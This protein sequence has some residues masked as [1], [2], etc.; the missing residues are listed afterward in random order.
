[1]CVCARACVA[2]ALFSLFLCFL[3]C[4]L[5]VVVWEFS[6]LKR[7]V[8]RSVGRSAV[9]AVVGP[10]GEKEEEEAEKEEHEKDK[11]NA[12]DEAAA[13]VASPVHVQANRHHQHHTYFHHDFTADFVGALWAMVYDHEYEYEDPPAIAPD[14]YFSVQQRTLLLLCLVYSL[15]IGVVFIA[16]KVH[17]CV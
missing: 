16:V 10:G 14:N 13:A 6:C 15:L 7:S 17:A 3:L 5:R 4:F 1:M 9:L 12:M 2:P 11:R 8:G